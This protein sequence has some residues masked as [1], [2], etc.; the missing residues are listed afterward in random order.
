MEPRYFRSQSELRRWFEKN[1][2]RVRVLWI[3]FFKRAAQK[4]GISYQQAVDESLCIGWI[5]GIRKSLG[6]ERWTIRFTPRKPRSK[7]SLVNIRRAKELEKAGLMAEAGLEAFRARDEENAKLYAYE[8]NPRELEP[9]HQAK[10]RR[11]AKA[12]AFWERQPP[13][14]RR[15][16]SFWVISTKKEETRLRRLAT[17]IEDSFHGRR[18]AQLVPS[19]RERKPGRFSPR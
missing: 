6:D 19:K 12:W 14:Y 11:N 2:G 18:I 4:S 16:A 3:G 8:A 1:H 17:L 15:V 5:D 7:W 13:G 10:F 9:E